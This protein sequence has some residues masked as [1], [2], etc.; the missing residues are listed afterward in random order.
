VENPLKQKAYV[1]ELSNDNEE[2]MVSDWSMDIEGPDLEDVIV[3]SDHNDNNA[4]EPKPV[5]VK[6]EKVQHTTSLVRTL[7]LLA[8]IL[9]L[10]QTS[11]SVATSVTDSK[12]PAQKKVKAEPSA[13]CAHSAPTI[14]HQL[15]VDTTPEHMK[16]RG[17]YCNVDLPA[18]MQV[19]QRWTKKYLST[20][21]LWAGSYDNIWNI[22]DEVLLLHAQLIFN[23]VS[24]FSDK[25]R[26]R[27]ATR[28]T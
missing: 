21:M 5:V 7:N 15:N 9:T 8:F 2:S 1:D 6:K 19:D 3:N 10:I 18:T 16:P 24:P 11:V 17:A 14:K 28:P 26:I 12:L 27:R 20:V 25:F 23:V 22:P 4:P 13:T